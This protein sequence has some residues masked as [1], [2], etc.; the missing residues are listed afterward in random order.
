MKVEMEAVGYIESIRSQVED[1]YWGGQESCIVLSN[2]FTP[3]ALQGMEEYSH[4]EI[5]FLMD[6][7]DPS[8]IIWGARRPRNNPTWPEV[9]I[10]AQRSK[11]RPNRI[12]CTICRILRREGMRLFVS[13]L[14]AIDKTPVLDMKPVL[15]EF[16]P[17]EK[18]RQPL[19]SRELMQDYWKK[20]AR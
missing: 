20:P 6:R 3:E 9:G 19:W 15:T 1:D 7:V 2:R 14:D 18:I 4:L 11:Y 10:F 12:G 5:I 13:E 8:K 17:Q 16:L